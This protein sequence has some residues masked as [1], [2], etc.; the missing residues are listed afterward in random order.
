M[1]SENDDNA[2]VSSTTTTLN[3][4]SSSSNLKK[5]ENHQMMKLKE[6]NAKYKSLLKLAKERITTQ[7][8]ELDELQ[9]TWYMS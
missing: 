3:P 6:A 4:S 2:T 7:A 9:G 8:E 5:S 1:M